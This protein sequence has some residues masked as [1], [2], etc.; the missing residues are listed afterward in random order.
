MSGKADSKPNKSASFFH[1]DGFLACGISQAFQVRSLSVLCHG[2]V[3]MYVWAAMLDH[4]F[5]VKLSQTN[6]DIDRLSCKFICKSVPGIWS[7]L[8]FKSD[9][10]IL[11]RVTLTCERKKT[12]DDEIRQHGISWSDQRVWVDKC[13]F[14]A[15]AWVI[16]HKHPFVIANEMKSNQ[17]WNITVAANWPFHPHQPHTTT[18]DQKRCI[19]AESKLTSL[20]FTVCFAW[21]FGSLIGLL[22]SS[23]DGCWESACKNESTE[24]M[25]SFKPCATD[26]FQKWMPA[27]LHEAL[28]SSH[29]NYA[30]LC[31]ALLTYAC[32]IVTFRERGKRGQC[33][34]GTL[35]LKMQKP[36]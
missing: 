15:A 2:I 12:G 16:S 33:C 5:S 29:V 26:C 13:P 17:A 14:V 19:P 34:C 22:I 27:C 8:F 32:K 36:H 24:S 4:L 35:P 6:R 18:P 1:G 23:R 11:S 9:C 28:C 3:P 7:I 25:A 30:F 21:V 10:S 31:Y 20:S